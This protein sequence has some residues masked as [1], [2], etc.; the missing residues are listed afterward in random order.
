[1]NKIYE[2]EEALAQYLLFHYGSPE[3]I[4]PYDFGP[5]NSLEFPINLVKI[6]LKNFN[7]KQA[8]ALDLGCAV[9]RSSFELYKNCKEVIGIDFSQSFIEASEKIK[10]NGFLNYSYQI[11]GKIYQQAQAKCPY[12]A[13]F[14]NLNFLVA[15]ALNLP[16]DLG[17]FDIVVMANLLDRV[18][19]PAQLLED[20]SNLIN[21][22]GRLIITSPFTWLKE[23]TPVTN[24]L[25]DQEKDLSSAEKIKELLS[26]SF[27]LVLEQNLPFLIREHARKFQ[28]S[29]AYLAAWD[30][31]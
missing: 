5:K 10:T 18:T 26:S 3:E 23:F 11:E 14:S 19:S 7:N 12:Q 13:N 31:I 30:K 29:V 17:S 16:K 27:N 15:D 4:L 9:G 1:M 22:G 25:S 8:R 20:V 2:T 6:G 21:P 28:W 24:W